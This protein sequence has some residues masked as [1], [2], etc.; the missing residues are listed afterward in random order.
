MTESNVCDPDEA[1]E[2]AAAIRAV[3]HRIRSVV[4]DSMANA[5]LDDLRAADDSAAGDTAYGI[6]RVGEAVLLELLESHLTAWLPVVVVAEGLPDAGY[7]EGVAVIPDGAE[8]AQARF[9][10]VVD[11]IDGTRGLM[12]G[13][14]SAWILTGVAAQRGLQVPTLRDIEVAV[15]TEVPPPKQT[16]AD[17]L[18][19]VRGGGAFAARTDL[20][21]GMSTPFALAPSTAGSA[22]HGFGQVMRAFPGGRDVLAAIDDDICRALVGVGLAGKASMFEDQYISTGGQLAELACGHDRWT[23][24]LRPLLRPLLADRGLPP[25][26]CCHPYDICT[27]LIAEEAGVIVAGID[28]PLDPP[29]DIDTD[30][31]WAGYAN[32]SIRS[33]VQPALN[34]ALKEHLGRW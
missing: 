27:A 34:A 15:Q 19:A 5:S 28:G 20:R 16:L 3:H 21:T 6:D 32:P 13:K 4:V 11:P 31:A 7:G 18:W 10:V 33:A 17:S 1:Q 12:Y 8:P 22:A 2:L 14:R 23:A 9:R 26:L 30:V 25:P 29:L 24:D